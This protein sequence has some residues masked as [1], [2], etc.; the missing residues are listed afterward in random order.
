MGDAT[1]LVAVKTALGM[2]CGNV[3]KERKRENVEEACKL[4][5]KHLRIF[6]VKIFRYGIYSNTVNFQNTVDLFT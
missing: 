5:G 4:S 6:V 3:E 2:N 1:L